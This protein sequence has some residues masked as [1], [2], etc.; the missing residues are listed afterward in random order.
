ME[1]VSA[2]KMRRAVERALGTRSYAELSLEL[3]V[4]LSRYQEIKHPLLTK[5]EVKKIL[6]IA[7]GSN[8]GLC[9]SFNANINRQLHQ[10]I[11]KF[12]EQTETVAIDY[13]TVGK[14][15]EHAIKRIKGKVIASFIN[16]SNTPTQAEISG[17]TK[18]VI[19]E[20]SRANYDRV[21][22]IYT[23]FI[24]SLRYLAR[25]QPLLPLSQENI[26][27]MIR[28]LGRGGIEEKDM[29]LKN[30]SLYLFEPSQEEILNEV[31]PRLTAV[32]IH[33]ALLESAASEHSARMMAMRNASD[34]AE[35]MID[36]L[37]LNYNQA[38]QA[39]ITREIA[40]ISAGAAALS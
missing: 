32:Q 33:Q 3:L 21:V 23:D 39:G 11:A 8:K 13:I 16:F 12:S 31:L 25:I 36:E 26:K 4:D 9:G 38:R 14:K 6:A 27:Q 7:I 1:L 20:F 10:L 2:A 24:S 35:E 18:I 30:L 5:R 40:E 37:T 34:A 28:D 29:R 17:L 22:M 19:D 15:A